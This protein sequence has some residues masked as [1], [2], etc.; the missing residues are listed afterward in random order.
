MKIYN[1]F[2]YQNN[3]K[4]IYFPNMK[5]LNKNFIIDESYKSKIDYIINN[6]KN[7]NIIFLNSPKYIEKFATELSANIGQINKIEFKVITGLFRKR[8]LYK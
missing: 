2:L 8:L 7:K 4:Y 5:Q 1:Y 6:S 3:K